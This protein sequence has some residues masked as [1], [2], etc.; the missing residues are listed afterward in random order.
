MRYLL[1]L[2]LLVFVAIAPI[3]HATAAGKTARKTQARSTSTRKAVSRKHA[4]RKNTTTAKRRKTES[5]AGYR[6][7]GGNKV[8]PYK[9]RPAK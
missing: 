3:T 4:A 6:T 9:R 2:L 5:V 7:Q 1:K 8:A